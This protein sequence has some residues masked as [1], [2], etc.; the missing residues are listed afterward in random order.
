MNVQIDVVIKRARGY[1]FVD[2]FTEIAAGGLFVILTGILLFH[3]NAPQASFP[4]WFLSIAG[5][6]AI[7]KFFGILTAIL[8]LWWLKDHFTYPRTGFVRGNRVTAAQ[9]LIMIRNAILFLLLPIFGLLAASLIIAP[10]GSVLSSMPAWFPAGAG[11]IWAVLCVLA[12]E[13]MGL[14]RFR[15]VGVMILLAGVAV[16]IW[17]YAM[18]L[19]A[20]PANVQPELLQPP[21]LETINRTLTSLG[22]LT[23]ASG[24]ILLFSG[25]VTFLRYRKENPTPYT[26]GI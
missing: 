19:P 12:G 16:G 26:E 10:V 5:E 25:V 7:A 20:F 2:G 8:T 13:W 24:V 11:L 17:Q 4:P 18:G 23:L 21:V 14:H 1:W 22:F 9:V 15:L 3:G 6:V